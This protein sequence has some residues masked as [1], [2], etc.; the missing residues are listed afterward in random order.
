MT[1]PIVSFCVEGN[2]VPKGRPR[3]V[4]GRAFTPEKTRQGEAG[5][6]L[7]ASAALRGSEHLL[8][9]AGPLKLDL[10]LVL[11]PMSSP[12]KPTKPKPHQAPGKPHHQ[13]PDL[14]NLLKLVCDALNGLVWHDDAQIAEVT[15]RKIWGTTGRTEVK[16]WQI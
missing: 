11:A 12:A 2:P 5:F 3:F 7:G 4:G 10:V 14:D 6:V 13:K 1:D 15:V 8:P 9:L 16:V